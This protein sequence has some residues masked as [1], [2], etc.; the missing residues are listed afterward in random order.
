[1]RFNG[2]DQYAE[3][4]G[5][6]SSLG[7]IG[8]P[9]SI[10]TWVKIA[11]GE[12]DG[13]IVHLSD[14]QNG[15]GWCIP[16][17]AVDGG[18]FSA[19]SFDGQM[20]TAI[21]SDTPSTDAWHHVVTTWNSPNG[22]KLYV[23]GVLKATTPQ[24]SFAAANSPV[25]LHLARGVTGCV[26]DKGFL[27]ATIDDTKVYNKELSQSQIS[28]LY[29]SNIDT[30]AKIDVTTHS[31]LSGDFY[32]GDN[33]ETY[34]SS[35]VDQTI[36]FNPA[37]EVI[38]TSRAG[39]PDNFTARWTGYITPQYSENYTFTTNSDDGVR[40]YIN[41]QLIIDDW[42]AHGP[43]LDSNS[44]S[45][46][47]G[48]HYPIKLEYQEL[49]GGAVIQLF[50]NSLSVPQE[51]IP[52]SSLSYGSSKTTVVNDSR[53]S[54]ITDGLVGLWS[55]DGK[56]ISWFGGTSYAIDRGNNPTHDGTLVDISQSSV[57][58]GKIGQALLF[59]GSTSCVTTQLQMN[60]LSHFTLSGW[61]NLQNIN[62]QG[63]FGQNDTIEF[64]FDGDGNLRG[65]AAGGSGVDWP[66]SAL[67]LNIWHHV[68]FVGDGTHEILYV[69]G[70]SVATAPFT[71]SNYGNSTYYFNIGG[72]GI[73]GAAG[74]Y[75]DGKIDD[76]RAYTRA[77]S[78]DEINQLYRIAK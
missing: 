46:I 76:V 67:K 62:P 16:F 9:Y 33:F 74:D 43:A 66:A 68:A 40:L 49:G 3:S 60:D 44:L 50:W 11:P 14:N 39:Q 38:G 32:A 57:T 29:T 71:T 42:T 59:N 15:Y 20:I 41:N 52:S 72:C 77:L 51:I 48:H 53:N 25:Y 37:D 22:L 47:A 18:K 69:D 63:F 28:A 70:Q 5:G 12:T 6:I 58:P 4:D 75:F 21:Q 19:I 56:D 26:G 27:D 78:A 30:V 8:A 45:L 24:A 55:F 1:M 23:D 10:S 61:V 65:W 13:N 17:L 73:W 54:R 64:G 34:V 7:T 2:L 35:A 31:G 36:D